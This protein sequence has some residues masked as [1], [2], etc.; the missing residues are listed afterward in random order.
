MP[1]LDWIGKQAVV[2]HHKQVPFHL[3]QQNAAHSVGE[4]NSGNLLIEG[5]NL[6]ALKALLPYYAGQVKCIYIDP[7]YNTG[8]EN[9]VY[10]D[11]V[12][13]PAI[14]EWLGRAVGK[15]DEDLSRHDKWLCMMYPRLTLLRELLREDGSFW[16][17][18]DDN[19]VHHARAILDEIFGERN[20][21]AN[22][23]WQKK[24]SPQNDAINFSTM[25]DYILVYA[26]RA[27]SS[28]EDPSGWQR[29]LLPRETNQDMRYTNPDNDPRGDWTSVDYTCNK[30]AEERPN[31]FYP[32]Q[33]P[34]TGK[35]IWPSRLRV[36]RYAR[37]VHEQH[38]RENQIWWGKTGESGP[39]L[40]RFRSEVADGIVPSTWWDRSQAGDNQEARREFRNLFTQRED[41]FSTPKPTRLIQRILQIATDPDDIVLDAFAGS[42]TTGHAVLE[43]NR[44]D[45]GK[46]R[47]ILIELEPQI[48]R[49]IA[50]ERLRRVIE[51]YTQHDSR[52]NLQHE[53]GLGSGFSYYEI[54]EPLFDKP[55]QI[56]KEITFA[57]LARYIF[58][59]ETGQPMP[60]SPN[61]LPPFLG[62]A[63]GVGV[64]LLYDSISG[65]GNVLTRSVLDS[66]PRYDGPKVIYGESCLLSPEW[67][68]RRGVTFRQIPYDIRA[69]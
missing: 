34:N 66:L 3:L 26:K 21:I 63:N 36:W 30:T 41:D 18:I 49:N 13:S 52:G 11:N 33:N 55:G 32:I 42:G 35:E 50:A 24:Q 59:T 51:G 16:M 10:N 9:W 6:L 46:R 54:G 61:G 44:G 31:L 45:S 48:A 43:Q 62:S 53:F 28:R 60:E 20:F 69:V 38:A 19:E 58:F 7:P 12:N 8:N 67:L 29:Q 14:K 64:Y 23:V 37:E 15:E 40:K 4:P 22:I 5:D 39:R 65:D 1:T 47:F 27:K 57:D 17:S 2:N 56:R 25:H 68:K